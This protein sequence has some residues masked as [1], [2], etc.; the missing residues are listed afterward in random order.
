MSGIRFASG[1]G[2]HC[3]GVVGLPGLLLGVVNDGSIRPTTSG[4]AGVVGKTVAAADFA[5]SGCS[6]VHYQH[7]PVLLMSFKSSN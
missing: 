4:G 6:S 5:G 1:S 7:L 3:S 2:L